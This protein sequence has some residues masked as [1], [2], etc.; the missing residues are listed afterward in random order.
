MTTSLPRP[1]ARPLAGVTVALG[2]SGTALAWAAR[3]LRTLGVDVRSGGAGPHGADL[4][5]RGWERAPGLPAGTVPLAAAYA[6]VAAAL[7]GWRSQRRLIVDLD[8]VAAQVYLPL[9][10]AAATG[11][12]AAASPSS[13]QLVA[14]GAL[15]VDLGPGDEDAYARLVEVLGA[16]GDDPELVAAAAQEWR[17]PVTPYRDRGPALAPRSLLD[18]AFRACPTRT[19]PP[20]GD[21]PL[22]G[23]VVADLTSVWS[24]PLATRLL[25]ALGATVVKVEPD[26]RPDG[27]RG[28]PGG[29]LFAALDVGKD[30]VA[31]DLHD[32]GDHRT[33]LELVAG[34]NLVIDNA[35]PR[36]VGNLGVDHDALVLVRPDVL[37]L[38]LPA[39]GPGRP[40]HHWVAYGTGVHAAMGLGRA[41]DGTAVAPLVSYPDPVTGHA[42]AAAAVA[43]LVA[44]ELG[45]LPAGRVELSL[46]DAIAPLL[47]AGRP[48]PDPLLAPDD[49]LGARLAAH[50]PAPLAPAG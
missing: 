47:D 32:P 45:R 36:V 43:L 27:L 30:H 22:A 16:D 25:A 5:G 2:G 20:R 44:R 31:L 4:A 26:C 19:P 37:T 1:T 46:A 12:Q 9:A 40:E 23:V 49:G 41:A 3:R 21:A 8:E 15:C 29:H 7:A 42:G 24:G 35:S 17:L 14:G 39:F 33:F 48:T 28:S 34:A 50:L 6:L 18:V 10:V 38:G 11:T 13:P